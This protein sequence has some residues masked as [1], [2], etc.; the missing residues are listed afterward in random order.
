MW[1]MEGEYGG[2]WGSD[3]VRE[4]LLCGGGAFDVWGSSRSIFDLFFWTKALD[5]VCVWEFRSYNFRICLYF[6]HIQE[7]FLAQNNFVNLKRSLM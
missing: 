4:V 2:A 7:T 6:K 1:E 3:G 5:D